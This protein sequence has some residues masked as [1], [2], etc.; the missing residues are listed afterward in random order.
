[1]EDRQGL[2]LE[3]LM[4]VMHQTDFSIVDKTKVTG[5][6]IIINQCN[7]SGYKEYALENGC[8]WRMISVT[9]RGLAK[10]RNL[11]IENATGDIILL[12]DDDE[13]LAEGYSDIILN[14][15]K[16]IPDA[17]AMVFNVNRINNP[18]K[19]K[20]YRITKI[21]KAPFYRG[22]GSVMLTFRLSS[23]KKHNIKMCEKFGAGTSW[24]GGEDS[25]FED[26]IR[27]CGLK[28]YEYPATIATIDYGN[29][30]TWFKGY[31]E[32]AFYNEGAFNQHKYGKNIILKYLRCI[33]SCYRLR[34][35]KHL[36]FFQKMKWMRLGMK[37]MKTNIPYKEYIAHQK[38]A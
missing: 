37:G 18:M 11:G 30:S 31:R 4:S 6:A 38:K 2:K 3:I 17:D 23:I 19:K 33:Y 12:C 35:E 29:G 36:N 25:L 10:S 5:D 8:L 24:G 9:D 21:K 1:M 14:A 13:L 26:D 16:E 15:Y 34:K 32:E 20:Y 27:K 7:D 28:M 22:Y